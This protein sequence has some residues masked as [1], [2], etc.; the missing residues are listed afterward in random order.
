MGVPYKVITL[1]NRE[2]PE[3]CEKLQ[4]LI[5]ASGF[6]PDCV[7]GIETGGRFV[8]ENIFRD[9]PHEYVRLQRPSTASKTGVIRSIIRLLPQR[10]T[11]YLRKVEARRLSAKFRHLASMP[12]HIENIISQK[13]KTLHIPDISHH[14]RILIV[15]DAIDS[16]MTMEAVCRAVRNT[17]HGADI[18][19]AVITVTEP[20]P[21]LKSDYTL[22][23]DRTLVRF[24]WSNDS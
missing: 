11:N 17:S 6:Q 10:V 2:F 9:N 15:D 13:I 20:D 16:G 1:G 7:I 3:A 18:R 23:N 19:T 21:L 8:A 12:E 24:P 5:T 4:A 22:F 14:D